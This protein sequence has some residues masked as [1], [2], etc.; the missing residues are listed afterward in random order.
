MEQEDIRTD[1]PMLLY[2][3]LKSGLA[4]GQ[5]IVTD[6][7][8]VYDK[9]Y[10]LRQSEINKYLLDNVQE[11]QQKTLQVTLYKISD[12][13]IILSEEQRNYTI[14]QMLLDGWQYS[15]SFNEEGLIYQTHALKKSDNT[16]EDLEDGFKWT[17]AQFYMRSYV[18]IPD[19]VKSAFLTIYVVNCTDQP[20]TPT[21][22]S[23]NFD[24]K[25]LTGVTWKSAT[26]QDLQWLLSIQPN[27]KDVWMST[28]STYSDTS[29][30][31]WS[32]P[33]QVVLSAEDLL[34]GIKGTTSV[35]V[36]LFS[37]QDNPSTASIQ[38][39]FCHPKKLK[40]GA[41]NPWVVLNGTNESVW[42]QSNSIWKENAQ[43]DGVLWKT[44]RVCTYDEDSNTLT[45]TPWT[46]PVKYIDIDGIIENAETN[47]QQ[48]ANDAIDEATQA[49]Q[50]AR[51]QAEDVT[52]AMT[53]AATQF[54]ALKDEYE[55]NVTDSLNQYSNLTDKYTEY[56]GTGGKV[57]TAI[58]ELNK[59]VGNTDQ[60]ISDMQAL[61]GYL[62]PYTPTLLRAR[63]IDGEGLYVIGDIQEGTSTVITDG[64]LSYKIKD[65]N[66]S[67]NV[68]N[69][70]YLRKEDFTSADITGANSF[71]TKKGVV[72]CGDFNAS[73]KNLSNSYVVDPDNVKAE[74][75]EYKSYT[76]GVLAQWG[77][78]GGGVT[79]G[80][81]QPK[82]TSMQ[83]LFDTVSG[84]ISTQVASATSGLSD[85]YATKTQLTQTAQQIQMAADSAKYIEQGKI[86]DLAKNNIGTITVSDRYPLNGTIVLSGSPENP[87]YNVEYYIK[88]YR[89]DGTTFLSQSSKVVISEQTFNISKE[90][91]TAVGTQG[92]TEANYE[93]DI[94]YKVEFTNKCDQAATITLRYSVEAALASFG[95]GSSGIVAEVV[96]SIKNDTETIN[97]IGSSVLNSTSFG[98]AVSSQLKSL[99]KATDDTKLASI[100]GSLNEVTTTVAEWKS[101]GVNLS[102]MQ[103]DLQVAKDKI[104]GT[105]IEAQLVQT[106]TL[107]L[108]ATTTGDAYIGTLTLPAK[109]AMKTSNSTTDYY[110]SPYYL[111]F[112]GGQLEYSTDNGTTWANLLSGANF[113]LGSSQ[114]EIKIRIKRNSSDEFLITEGNSTNKVV[115]KAGYNTVQ[116]MS[117]SMQTVSS[118]SNTIL[119]QNGFA[120]LTTTVDSIKGEVYSNEDDPQH[121]GQKI[122]RIGTLEST[123]T[124]LMNIVGDQ[125][126]G[127]AASG[128]I[129]NRIGTLELN[130]SETNF[131]YLKDIEITKGST[132]AAFELPYDECSYQLQFAD[133]EN[134]TVSYIL[135]ADSN[136]T[137]TTGFTTIVGNGVI[138]IDENEPKILWIKY[139]GTGGTNKLTVKVAVQ[140]AVLIS[141][142]TVTPHNIALSVANALG[143]SEEE[144]LRAAMLN[145]SKNQITSVLTAKD[146][147]GNT[148][149]SSSIIQSINQNKESSV[150][151]SADQIVLNGD[152]IA[153][154]IATK[155]LNVDNLT[156]INSGSSTAN[157]SVVQYIN[158][159][160]VI[161][162]NKDTGDIYYNGGI[163]IE[164][165]K[166]IKI[167]PLKLYYDFNG[168]EG[169]F[170]DG[171]TSAIDFV[172]YKQSNDEYIKDGA[173]G[174]TI[175]IGN[176]NKVYITVQGNY[177]YMIATEKGE[178]DQSLV[179]PTGIEYN[180]SYEITAKDSISGVEYDGSS[181]VYPLMAIGCGTT[182]QS[183]FNSNGSGYF[184]GG[185]ISWDKYRLDE[186]GQVVIENGKKKTGGSSVVLDIQGIINAKAGTIAGWTLAAKGTAPSTHTH[187]FTR[188][189]KSGNEY[190]YLDLSPDYGIRGYS[191]ESLKG[192]DNGPFNYWLDVSGNAY[193]AQNKARFKNDG[194]FH[195]GTADEYIKFE[196]GQLYIQGKSLMSRIGQ[197]ALGIDN[198][199]VDEHGNLHPSSTGSLLN[200]FTDSA[201]NNTTDGENPTLTSWT[202]GSISNVST[203]VETNTDLSAPP[204]GKHVKITYSSNVESIAPL[205]RQSIT[206]Q[207]GQYYTLSYYMKASTVT[208]NVGL[209]IYNSKDIIKEL[210]K[211]QYSMDGGSIPEY[212]SVI[213]GGFE[214]GNS[215]FQNLGVNSE[216]TRYCITFKTKDTL[217]SNTVQIGIGSAEMQSGTIY[218][219]S[220]K[221]EL[222]MSPTEWINDTTVAASLIS[223]SASSISAQVG[224]N[225]GLLVEDNAT[226]LSNKTCG[227]SINDNATGKMS[228]IFPVQDYNGVTNKGFLADGNIK[229]YTKNVGNSSINN[230][231]LK[232][233]I[234]NN[235]AITTQGTVSEVD[236]GALYFT[237][238]KNVTNTIAPGKTIQG[239]SVNLEDDDPVILFKRKA[240]DWTQSHQNYDFFV[241]NPLL[242][243]NGASSV[244]EPHIICLDY[245][246]DDI[247]SIISSNII[248]RYQ[249]QGNLYKIT[250]TNINGSTEK[251]FMKRN[252][253]Y[254]SVLYQCEFDELN[255]PIYAD[256]SQYMDCCLSGGYNFF[257]NIS[258][259]PIKITKYQLDTSSQKIRRY[260]VYLIP[261]FVLTNTDQNTNTAVLERLT[262][263]NGN[264]KYYIS[265][266]CK[267]AYYG[268]AGPSGIAVDFIARAGVETG[269]ANGA[270]VDITYGFGSTGQFGPESMYYPYYGW[271]D[272]YFVTS[273]KQDPIL[274]NGPYFKEI[275]GS[276]LDADDD[277]IAY[278]E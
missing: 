179:V 151:I 213:G 36:T 248:S 235:V 9:Y 31:V 6:T 3:Q 65:D 101:S 13:T 29:T 184:A 274:D 75:K 190:N 134:T 97:S 57:E 100:F 173:C 144:E 79:V 8:Q 146:G 229:W 162:V 54:A 277:Y 21:G 154:A 227:F 147:S 236:T 43:P 237:S 267:D 249:L 60:V 48:A 53:E 81:G 209:V 225:M 174:D 170:V 272:N 133:Q 24:T 69:G 164:G 253:K 76:N 63:T 70:K 71:F 15:S 42:D 77:L 61:G 93:G 239:A 111:I 211:Y 44:S 240:S 153:K 163:D 38:N 127:S 221:L 95:I 230:I 89:E 109:A 17:Q 22:G 118:I 243:G 172:I 103:S 192:Q 188:S 204:S 255:A 68:V 149:A 88:A 191:S 123:S 266:G 130:Q 47:A 165:A 203:V 25:H 14:N 234:A 58:A 74:L 156:Y 139:E 132:S 260:I 110:N 136:T 35:A 122:S 145:L 67:V 175:N 220:P 94:V 91:I 107:E 159:S 167:T 138:N 50:Q 158:K 113:D 11:K 114:Q 4:E 102:V 218:I 262:D 228:S 251:Y 73:T 56:F 66:S 126:S 96:S 176:N 27:D 171:N 72:I 185:L 252:G 198:G 160:E 269:I 178:E 197:A 20:K 82:V 45:G 115:V 148:I 18:T 216:W 152:V 161:S 78:T 87:T 263:G 83:A 125:R 52:T 214:S 117:K 222:S 120:S 223:Q 166:N 105:V 143:N 140:T 39:V 124:Y 1:N 200:M 142:I 150:Q 5:D 141:K 217:S 261:C 207:P 215:T 206:L 7:T 62:N 92:A 106:D 196:N 168:E 90:D 116:A 157:K 131:S 273:N 247:R 182:G 231:E 49:I 137:P 238:W 244:T 16:L 26:N 232:N 226:Y 135:T 108:T 177:D 181:N 233:V 98:T 242:L 205:I 121:P 219:S 129:L 10:K 245:L 193:L 12:T 119:G 19:I 257:G 23:Y 264:Y 250:K 275:E 84:K 169:E 186:N 85:T 128:T 189:L 183:V 28:A 41:A 99:T 30:I 32:T 194:S 2:R 51:Q 256:A 278:F 254:A 86:S 265:N 224:S 55:Q 202:N 201:F 46:Q 195:L 37:P 59:Q 258:D 80:D 276:A 187:I 212:T 241:L 33:T 268:T 64:E 112:D 246:E 34:R 208:G 180:I 104:E 210:Y 270:S 259:R 155:S 40:Q 199:Y 271:D